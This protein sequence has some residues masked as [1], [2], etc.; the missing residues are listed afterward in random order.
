MQVNSLI[1]YARGQDGLGAAYALVDP[2]AVPGGTYVYRLI[3]LESDGNRQIHGPFQRTAAMMDFTEENPIATTDR[4]V[5]LRW[6][7]RADEYYRILRSTNLLAGKEGFRPIATGIPATPPENEYLDE[8]AG[9]I[10]MYL[11]QSEE[12]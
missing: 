9:R 8:D 5:L 1:L 7:S 2:G 12:E 10:G 4:G 3:E 6:L 11:I